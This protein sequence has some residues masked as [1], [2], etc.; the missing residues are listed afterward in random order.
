MRETRMAIIAIIHGLKKSGALSD[1]DLSAISLELNAVADTPHG[2]DA[3]ISDGLKF[4]AREIAKA[5][6]GQ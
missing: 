1:D 2:Y 3:A 4:L 6:R 5:P